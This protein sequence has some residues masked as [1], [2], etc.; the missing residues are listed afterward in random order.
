LRADV[1]DVVASAFSITTPPLLLQQQPLPFNTQIFGIS[2][3]QQTVHNTL[4][5][6]IF[7]STKRCT[8]HY[9]QYLNTKKNLKGAQHAQ[10]GKFAV[11]QHQ[12]R[13]T[14]RPNSDPDP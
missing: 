5:F 13:C 1:L 12:Q 11:P 14:A 9:F 7:K 3:D 8:T 6:D 2:S 10:R 4:I